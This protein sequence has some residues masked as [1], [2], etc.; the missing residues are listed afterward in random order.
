MTTRIVSTS[1]LLSFFSFLSAQAVT[2]FTIAAGAWSS[3]ANWSGG[4]SPLYS[5][6]D[7]LIIRH[8]ITIG[9]DL[10][11]NS[12]AYLQID[13]NAALCGHID[14]T[15]YSGAEV[16]KYGLLELDAL[17]IT[18]GGVA[19][20]PPGDLILTS[21]GVIS[22]NGSMNVNCLMIV[23]Q[24]FECRPAA[25]GINETISQNILL[26]PNPGNGIFTLQCNNAEPKSI[27][28]Q[29][30]LGNTIYQSGNTIASNTEID[31][32]NYAVGVYIV[33]VQMQ[34]GQVFVEKVVYR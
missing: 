3:N 1:V 19:A 22:G 21:Y 15:L 17:Y 18:G 32:R 12:G 33:K 8:F 31:L 9:N 28:V 6:S 10:T 20:E 5:V 30:L 11:L 25:T 7:T 23:G 4:T 34:S 16:H 27:I 2:W 13:S 14:M 29:N 26:Y 24:W